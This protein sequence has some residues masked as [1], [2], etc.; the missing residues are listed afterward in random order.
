MTCNVLL[1]FKPKHKFGKRTKFISV[2]QEVE[3]MRRDRINSCLAEL[4]YLV[5]A[6]ISEERVSEDVYIESQSN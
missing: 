6:A 4:K 5:P 1:K 2:F 3:K